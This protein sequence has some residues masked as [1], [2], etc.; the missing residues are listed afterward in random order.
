MKNLE[1]ELHI[2]PRPTQTVSLSIPTDT[3][4]SLEKVAASRDMSV[5]ALMKLY[6]GN[7]LRQDI[8]K[9]FSERVLDSAAEVLARHI[10]SPEEVEAILNELKV[11]AAK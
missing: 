5:E 8:A 4:T 10:E 11:E 6:I 9:M 1:P 2:R 3:L 7:A